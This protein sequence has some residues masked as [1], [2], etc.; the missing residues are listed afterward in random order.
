MISVFCIIP[1]A[2]IKAAIVN[3]DMLVPTIRMGV[4]WVLFFM[5]GELAPTEDVYGH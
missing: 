1:I 5:K 4:S 3:V 2:I